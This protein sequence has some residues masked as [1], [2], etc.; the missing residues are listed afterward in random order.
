MTV[1]KPRILLFTGD[2]K[3]KTTAALGMAL[4]AAGHGMKVL[5]IQFV[6]SDP[7][8]GEQVAA[9]ALPGI[10]IIQTGRGF[11]PP[12]ESPEFQEHR[13]AALAGLAQA[14][15]A[16]ESGAWDV[17]VLDEVCLAAGKNLLTETEVLR[18][19]DAARPGAIIVMTGRYAPPGLVEAADTVTEMRCVKHAYAAGIK[20]WKGVEH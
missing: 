4:R 13:E 20:A 2:G 8:T 6:K 15:R 17:L 19:L 7:R 5:V 18:V 9:S 1:G 16:L 12:K 11:L 10:K 14:G 3:G